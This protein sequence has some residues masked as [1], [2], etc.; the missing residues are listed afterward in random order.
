MTQQTKNS[1]V[2]FCYIEAMY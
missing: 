1:E 2:L